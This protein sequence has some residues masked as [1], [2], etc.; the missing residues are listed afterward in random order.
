M[1]TTKETNASKVWHERVAPGS[2]LRESLIRQ[3]CHAVMPLAF[4]ERAGGHHTAL[5]DGEAASIAESAEAQFRNG[6]YA[7]TQEHT[8]K[9]LEW[10]RRNRKL[11]E[12][13]GITQ[14]MTD[15][16]LYYRW[17][18]T[19]AIYGAWR[20]T[21]LAIWEIN[22]L[23]EDGVRQTHEYWWGAWQSSGRGY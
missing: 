10:T 18:G 3:F 7:L 2:V 9:G 1:M 13:A 19:N 23:D 14:Q 12:Q 5:T 21:Y 11:A 22:Y 6:G 17:V 15:G 20:S 4:G 8:D 16:F